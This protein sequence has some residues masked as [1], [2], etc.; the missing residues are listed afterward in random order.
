MEAGHILMAMHLLVLAA[1]PPASPC[2]AIQVTSTL[3]L[4]PFG[5]RFSLSLSQQDVCTTFVLLLH[6]SVF[7]LL[8]IICIKLEKS[9][10]RLVLTPRAAPSR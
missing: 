2:G 8:K 9:N 5:D 7:G 6:K 10:A 4:L 1:Q 3:A